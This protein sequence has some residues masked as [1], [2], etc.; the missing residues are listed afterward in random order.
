[1]FVTMRLR[2]ILI[3]LCT[4]LICITMSVPVAR[5]QL[6]QSAQPKLVLLIVVDQ[7]NYDYL[8]RFQDKFGAGGF[9]F[10]MENGANFVNCRFPQSTTSTAVGHS[11][12]ASGALP[13]STGIV[14]NDW[15]DRRKDKEVSA[16]NDDTVQMIGANGTGASCRAMLG[17]T[18]GDEMKLATNGRSKVVTCSLKDRGAVFTAGRLGNNAFWWDERTGS[19]VSSSQ[20]GA[21]IPGWVRAF[22]DRHYAD[23]YFGK[24]WQRLL[25]E[26]LYTASTRDDYTYERSF[27]GDGRQFPHV[28]TGGASSPNEQYYETF[29]MTPFANQMLADFA[30]EAIEK[31]NLGQH[32]EADMLSVSFSSTDHLGHWY[33]PYSQEIQDMFLRLDQTM[34][35]FLQYVDQ[36]VGLDKTLIVVTGD[37][38]VMPIPEFLKE[39]GLDSGRIDPKAFKTLLDNALDSKLAPDDWISAFIPPNVYLNLNTIDKQKFRQPEVE[40]LAAKLARSSVPGISD[41]FTAAQLYMNQAPA[42]PRIEGVRKNYYWGRSGELVVVQRPGFIFSGDSNGTNH[43]SSYA[44][45]S[46][47]PLIMAG[48][49]IRSGKYSEACTPADIAPTLSAILN[50]AAPSQSEGRVLSEALA[51]IQGPSRPLTLQ[52]GT[53][54]GSPP[55]RR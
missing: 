18:I 40:Q 48:P 33:G 12:I 11:I 20:F 47:V 51:Q 5:A 32:L 22:N 25:P 15:Y 19:F 27:N 44:Y 7:F 39:K 1:M 4:F 29:A 8:S 10:L 23:S 54:D 38:G 24:P 2:R 3:L 49:T 14:G 28:I 26:N 52:V 50:I 21:A 45:D 41:V 13:W 46:Q 37:H 35:S 31:E 6:N 42:G 53:T 16:V 34:A 43:G 30:K 55:P 9:R 17:T 36:K